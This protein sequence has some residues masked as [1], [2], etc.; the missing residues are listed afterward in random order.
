MDQRVRTGMLSHKERR[1]V[2]YPGRS[3]AFWMLEHIVIA[4]FGWGDAGKEILA[5]AVASRLLLVSCQ[6]RGKVARRG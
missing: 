6:S 5:M 2:R 4:I 3:M 1:S